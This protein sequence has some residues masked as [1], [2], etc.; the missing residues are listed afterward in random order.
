VNG[1]LQRIIHTMRHLFILP[2][3]GL[4]IGCR[5]S[6]VGTYRND[7]VGRSHEAI[8]LFPDSI[9]HYQ[10]WADIPLGDEGRWSLN[11]DTL[12]LERSWGKD[13]RWV[14]RGKRLMIIDPM[15]REVGPWEFR[16][17]SAQCEP[18]WYGN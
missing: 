15:T 5:N 6:L 16:K 4:L 11:G 1:S 2:Y 3:L 8:T 17:H 10:Y 14:V 13:N 9:Y 7:H 12:R 18:L